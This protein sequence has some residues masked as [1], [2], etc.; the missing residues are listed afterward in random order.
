CNML[1]GFA[2]GFS[3]GAGVVA[4]QYFGA[5]DEEKVSRTV[6]TFITFMIVLCVALTFLGLLLVPTLIRFIA[7]PPEVAVEQHI[8]LTIYFAGLSGLLIYNM[9]SAI[10]RA[11]GNS[12]LPFIFLVCSATMNII[13][14][15]VLVIVFHMGTAGVAYATIIS[16][17]L[18]AVLIVVAL[19]R[20]ESCVRFSPK[21]L[22]MDWQI[23]KKI[24]II[25]LPSS[26]Q[27]AIT[28]F[29]NIFVQSYINYF[30][31][32]VMGGWT[33]YSKMDQLLFLPM[34]CLGLA[35]MTFVGQNYGSG[36]IKR[37]KKGANTTLF[38]GII[39]TGV[40]LVPIVIFAPALV[41]FFIS[42]SETGV[43]YYGTLFLRYISPFY[44]LCVFNQIYGSALRGIG[45]SQQPMYVM[46]FSFVFARQLYLY[47]VSH[48]VSNT[49]L[50]IAM[51]YPF[52]WILCSSIITITYLYY[53]HQEEKKQ[54][55]KGTLIEDA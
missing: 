38:L 19:L 41:N 42:A 32:D 48:Y 51:G 12:R 26:I 2:G 30:G 15:L 5:G 55:E 45:R 24:L 43:I 9:G 33:A 13:M 23:L 10:F 28:A 53:F 3:T 4:S 21:K 31:S 7:S 39:S 11:V 6:H 22:C 49:V 17:G 54:K 52:G 1:V 14:D 40:L 50:P 34:Q 8:Y 46:L 35:A 20:T 47:I 18:S 44:L 36:K 29:S 25:G 16:Q 27:M 37:A